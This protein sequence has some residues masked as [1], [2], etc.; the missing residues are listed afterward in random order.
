MVRAPSQDPTACK[1]MQ[2]LLRY[3]TPGTQKLKLSHLTK[4]GASH[5]ETSLTAKPSCKDEARVGQQGT[6][7]RVWAKKGS[8]PRAPRDR[9]YDWA[10]IFGAACPAR[11]ACAALVLPR[12]DTHAFNLHLAEIS[13]AVAEGAHAVVILDGAGYHG[14]RQLELP[15]N[16][17]LFRL[18]PYAPELNSAENIWEYLRKNKLANSIFETYDD[19]VEACCNAWSFFANDP[20]AVASITN[21][22]WAKVSA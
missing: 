15:E 16:L 18:P 21:R 2:L 11:G 3:R 12:A 22:N 7:T 20:A 14:A 19:I 5:A 10:Y 4:E 9:R 6:L 17:T 13:K 8:R 1:V